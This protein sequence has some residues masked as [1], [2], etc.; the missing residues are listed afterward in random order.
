MTNILVTGGAGYVGSILVPKLLNKNYKVTVL[1]KMWFGSQ[2]IDYI[3]NYNLK[4]I[5][6]DTRNKSLID[7]ISKNIDTVIH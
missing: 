1:D 5:K 3:K 4:I 7:K 6:G 2:G